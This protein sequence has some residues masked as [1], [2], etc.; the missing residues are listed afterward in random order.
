MRYHGTTPDTRSFPGDGDFSTRP[1][2]DRNNQKVYTRGLITVVNK[3]R[4]FG[5]SA[6]LTH[7]QPTNPPEKNNK[8]SSS[9]VFPK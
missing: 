1:I 3:G 7:H 6:K 2:A 4:S 8:V 9:P 5:F